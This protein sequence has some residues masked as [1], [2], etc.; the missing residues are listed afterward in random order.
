MS[1]SQFSHWNWTGDSLRWKERRTKVKYLRIFIADHQEWWCRHIVGSLRA[2]NA[3]GK[4]SAHG[5]S[6]AHTAADAESQLQCSWFPSEK[7]GQWHW[8]Q[9]GQRC[10]NPLRDTP[11][12]PKGKDMRGTLIGSGTF[13]TR[14]NI[15]PL[16]LDDSAKYFDSKR[17]VT[18]RKEG[19]IQRNY[20]SDNANMCTVHQASKGRLRR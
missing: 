6:A 15:N 20:N 14:A 13:L 19:H 2:E 12:R 16:H 5:S 17:T 11:G 1:S 3:V 9:P 4:W 10:P 8:D 18:S 7:T